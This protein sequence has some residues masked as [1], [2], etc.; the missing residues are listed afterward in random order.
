MLQEY[1]TNLL[2]CGKSGENKVLTKLKEDFINWVFLTS[3]ATTFYILNKT[4][5]QHKH[6][7]KAIQFAL[8]DAGP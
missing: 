5:F 8:N 4:I 3:K 2:V 6:I 1:D 7:Y